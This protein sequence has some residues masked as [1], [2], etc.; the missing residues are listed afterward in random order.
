MLQEAASLPPSAPGAFQAGSWSDMVDLQPATLDA[1]IAGPA[2]GSKRRRLAGQAKAAAGGGQPDSAQRWLPRAERIVQQ[3]DQQLSKALAAALD[4]CG[5]SGQQ[6]ATGA[7]A[8]ASSGRTAGPAETAASRA[9]VLEPFVQDR[10]EGAGGVGELAKACMCW[11][12]ASMKAC[13]HSLPRSPI[14]LPE[15]LLLLLLALQPPASC[16]ACYLQVCGSCRGHCCIPGC[17]VAGASQAA[18]GR[19]WGCGGGGRCG[20]WLRAVRHSGSHSRQSGTGHGW[21]QPHAALG[22]GPAKPVAGS[23]AEQQC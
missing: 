15:I 1:A 18:G 22:A 12:A 5:G 10:C 21:P 16:S 19:G 13:S 3:L 14:S 11:M 23:C 2:S 17:P 6:P 8:G 20:S 7:A 4:A 9:L